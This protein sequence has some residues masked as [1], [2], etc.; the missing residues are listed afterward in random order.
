VTWSALMRRSIRSWL[1]GGNIGL[2]TF[3]VK[4]TQCW[5]KTCTSGGRSCNDYPQMPTVIYS[6]GKVTRGEALTQALSTCRQQDMRNV[7]H[8]ISP[9]RVAGYRRKMCDRCDTG[10]LPGGQSVMHDEVDGKRNLLAEEMLRYFGE[11]CP[12]LAARCEIAIAGLPLLARREVAGRLQTLRALTNETNRGL[13]AAHVAVA[14]GQAPA[15]RLLDRA[16]ASIEHLNEI[17]QTMT[18]WMDELLGA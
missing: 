10:S 15:E 17:A 16:L 2:G 4:H 5:P 9:S 3:T 11:T 7:A 14:R 12:A 13:T 6:Q 8:S 18:G 1:E